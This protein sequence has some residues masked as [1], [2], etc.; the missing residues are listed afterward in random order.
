MKYLSDV[1]TYLL[2]ITCIASV[3]VQNSFHLSLI[4]LGFLAYDFLCKKEV[5]KLEALGKELEIKKVST[6]FET[7]I[8]LL[9]TKISSLSNKEAT[10]DLLNSL[11]KR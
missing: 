11:G 8:V 1:K 5:Y 10:K 9:E 3:I 4:I 2:I 7:R 6:E